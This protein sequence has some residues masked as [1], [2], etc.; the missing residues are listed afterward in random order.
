VAIPRWVQQ[1]P[2]CADCR[3]VQC[4]VYDLASNLITAVRPLETLLVLFSFPNFTMWRRPALKCTEFSVLE[5]VFELFWQNIAVLQSVIRTWRPYKYCR[6]D[7][8]LLK[9][10]PSGF[11]QNCLRK[12]VTFGKVNFLECKA[13]WLLCGNSS[14][15]YS[16]G[17]VDIIT[18]CKLS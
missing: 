2:R 10:R 3:C 15:P 12:Y 1:R 7:L 11:V 9:E 14:D 17:L 4:Y 8:E 18:G 5:V 13:A 6:W 16:G